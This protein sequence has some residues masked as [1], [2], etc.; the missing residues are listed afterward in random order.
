M[1]IITAT[2]LARNTREILDTV[3]S[4]G[5]TV[6]IE[7]NSR[8]IAQL[9]PPERFMTAAQALNGLAVP[10]LTNAQAGAWLRESKQNFEDTVRDPWV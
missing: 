4:S 1:Q 8:L 3:T 10:K 9:T 5:Q 2:D 6:G 7:R